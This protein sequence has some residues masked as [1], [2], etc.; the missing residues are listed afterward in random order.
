LDGRIKIRKKIKSFWEQNKGKLSKIQKIL[1]PNNP[2]GLLSQF[3]KL[4][5][6]VGIIIPLF[7]INKYFCAY[8]FFQNQ[9][10]KIRNHFLQSQS[11]NLQN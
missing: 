4:K 8:I 10:E 5:L 1:T 11:R 7:K 6:I 2:E 9:K 3:I